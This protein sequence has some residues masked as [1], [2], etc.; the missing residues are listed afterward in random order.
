MTRLDKI[1]LWLGVVGVALIVT[2]VIIGRPDAVVDLS[3]QGAYFNRDVG[4]PAF[5]DDA[6]APVSSAG[7]LDPSD[8]NLWLGAG[9]ALVAAGALVLVT[10]RLR[11]RPTD[12]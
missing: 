12:S 3:I 9:I 10:R 7:L 8:G 2:G 5:A 6:Q 11:A 1:A 4:S